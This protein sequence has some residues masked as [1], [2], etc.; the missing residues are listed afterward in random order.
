[1]GCWLKNDILV[2]RSPEPE[3]LELLYEMEN[4]TALWEVGSTLLPYSRYT[5][6][7][8]LKN[9]SQ[10]LFTERQ[11]R[12]IIELNGGDR[13]GMID[14]ADFD[15][16]NSRAEVCIGL[17]GR[18]R[19]CGYATVALQLLCEY[20]MKKLHLNQLYAYI[21]EKNVESSNLFLKNGFEKSAV[22]KE[23]QR[24]ENGY[25]N[26]VLVQKIVEK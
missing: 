16:L 1:M 26:V 5:L 7:E 23:W 12:F 24:T 25:S 11:A 21:P 10:D 6:R 3:D 9:S 2:L 19:K 14:L 22:L 18:F 17:L 15:P 20:A 8:Y 13:V 4:D